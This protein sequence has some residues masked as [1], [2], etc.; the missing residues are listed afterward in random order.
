MRRQLIA[1]QAIV[2]QGAFPGAAGCR[3]D[4]PGEMSSELN[5]ALRAGRPAVIHVKVHPDAL[6]ALCK[7]LFRKR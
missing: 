2:E 3:V 1:D 5:R 6:S 7:D 4:N